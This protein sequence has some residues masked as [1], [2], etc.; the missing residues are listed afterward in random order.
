MTINSVERREPNSTRRSRMLN[1]LNGQPWPAPGGIHCASAWGP[2]G[3]V[4]GKPYP[5]QP[6][7]AYVGYTYDTLYGTEYFDLVAVP[8]FLDINRILGITGT[9]G[10]APYGG[11][12]GHGFLMWNETSGTN[13]S[14]AKWRMIGPCRGLLT[15]H[16]GYYDGV[17]SLGTAYLHAPTGP[18]TIIDLHAGET[19]DIEPG[20]PFGSGPTEARVTVFWHQTDEDSRLPAWPQAAIIFYRFQSF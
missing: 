1:S 7:W 13:T 14:A 3:S 11:T 17:F 19:L 4:A 2:T 12:D 15:E 5:S 20:A 9:F 18:G 6:P 8:V 10:G 16:H